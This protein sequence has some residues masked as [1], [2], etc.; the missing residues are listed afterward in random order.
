M[1][2]LG[3]KLRGF[4]LACL[5]AVGLATTGYAELSEQNWPLIKEAFFSQRTIN[6]TDLMQMTAPLGAEN[7]GQV[8]IT[9]KVQ[10]QAN[11]S[12]KRIYILIDANPVPLAATYQFPHF[13]NQ[14]TLATR[15]RL[16]NDSTIRAIAETQSGALLMTSV[17]VNAGGGCA[18]T[19]SEDE[20]IVRASAGA[21]KFQLNPPYKLHEIASATLQIK[22]PMYT[23]LQTDATTKQAK[24]AFFVKNSDIQFDGV[25]VM[26]ILFG[27]GTA[28]NPYVK[29]E[30]DLPIDLLKEPVKKIEIFSQDNEGKAITKEFI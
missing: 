15:V 9:L 6:H 30:F 23:G 22:H 5:L 19:V 14:L 28:E 7:A 1:L 25:S 3:I 4:L 26:Q 11:D 17:R 27:V 24:P 18:G 20:A 29:F 16:D 10:N 2:L 12:I 8:P 21:I 13:F